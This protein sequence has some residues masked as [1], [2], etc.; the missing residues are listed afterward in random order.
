[1]RSIRHVATLVAIAAAISCGDA[2]GT[3]PDSN[4]AAEV[5]ITPPTSTISIGAQ[6]PLQARVQDPEGR[7]LP[8]ASV[9]WT[10]QDP[11][12]ATVSA[13]GVVTA[14][15]LGTTQVAASYNGKSAVATITV[16]KTPVAT[17]VVQPAQ[18]SAAAGTKVTLTAVAYDGSQN[19]LTDR[20]ITWSSSNPGV[21]TVDGAGVVSAVSAGTATL[22]ASSE[23]KSA[24]STITVSAGAVT[25]VTVT[26][27]PVQLVAGQT[28]QLAVTTRDVTGAVVT[29]RTVVW[30]SSNTAVATVSSQ[31]VVTGV[32]AGST[33]ITATSEGRS[34]TAAVT[35]SRVAVGTVAVSPQGLTL[36][37]TA[38]T[39]LSATV[40]DVNNAVVTDRAVSWATSDPGIATVSGSGVVTAVAPGSATI[41]ATSEGRSGVTVV[42]VPQVWVTPSTATI[43]VGESVTFTGNAVDNNGRRLNNQNFTWTITPNAN[44]LLNPKP[45]PTATLA[46]VSPGTVTITATLNGKSGSASLVVQ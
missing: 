40:R 29:G 32:G 28:T 8:G 24:T 26:P 5:A 27:S 21:A 14:I 10:V 43:R 20:G 35:V 15:K 11:S 22:T 33:T 12:I 41:T 13:A 46:G 38:S 37:P 9:L 17:I 19:A 31:G 39:P 36:V 45:G 25:T 44:P 30:S 42:T 34:G 23:G 4:V 2:S 6:L 7:V 18:V 1:M 16:Q 3:G